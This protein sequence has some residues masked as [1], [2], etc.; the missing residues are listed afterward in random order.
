MQFSFA[1][2][3]GFTG[4]PYR[5]VHHRFFPGIDRYYTP[6]ISANESCEF[7]TREKRDIDP[8][9]NKDTAVIPQI[10]TR[11]AEQFAFAAREMK[12]RG[13]TE[14]NLNLGCPSGTVVAK[15]K[16]AGMLRDPAALDSFL[17]EC[18]ER[19]EGEGISISLKTRL[20]IHEGTEAH[21]LLCVF[22]H[23][24]LS[25]LIVHPRVQKDIYRNTVQLSVFEEI[26]AESRNPVIYNGDIC[27]R[28]DYEVI[29]GRFPSVAGV[30]IGRGLIENP[31]L[32]REICGGPAIDKD[33]YS[34]FAAALYDVYEQEIQ[35]EKNVLFKLKDFWSF[36]SL[37]FDHGKEYVKDIRKA[38]NK[39]EYQ[40][41]VRALFRNCS[42]ME[43]E[44]KL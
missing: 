18:F 22:N 6:F 24:E 41:A 29:H 32:V 17:A 44:K 36:M 34:R 5:N 23:Y 2:M 20:G 27:T 25:E 37:H 42:L 4:F 14:V 8:A 31:A 30:M 28:A 1:P 35:G 38:G 9:N 40:A 10:L 11:N 33:E 43:P 21:A 7:M 39:A 19:L 16:G 15:G 12:K 13:Y 26:L 3:E